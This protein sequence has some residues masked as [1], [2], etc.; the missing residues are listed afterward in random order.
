MLLVLALMAAAAWSADYLAAVFGVKHVG[1]SRQ[2]MAGV[3]AGS[4]LGIV[5]GLPGLLLGPIAGAMN[6]QWVARRNRAQ[7]T[8]AG[9]AAVVKLGTGLAMVVVFGLAYLI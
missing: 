9:L 6:G 5:G 8:C 1:A 7:A 4:L 3:G 2:A